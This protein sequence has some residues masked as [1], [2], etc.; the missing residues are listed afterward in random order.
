MAEPTQ[1]RL[2][3]LGE[4][5]EEVRRDAEEHGLL[6]DSTP[7]RTFEDPDP[8]DDDKGV[9]PES[10]ARGVV[11]DETEDAPEPSEPA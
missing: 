5:I 2:D 10:P 11:D 4:Q 7:E 3:E 1:E 6:P 9:P 8:E